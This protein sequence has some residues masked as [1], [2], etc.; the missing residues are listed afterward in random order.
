MLRSSERVLEA[1]GI[2]Q[3]KPVSRIMTDQPRSKKDR[4]L[5]CLAGSQARMQSEPVLRGST[6]PSQKKINRTQTTTCF[7]NEKKMF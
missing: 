3:Y 7:R 1:N 4:V 5:P 6:M 2:Y